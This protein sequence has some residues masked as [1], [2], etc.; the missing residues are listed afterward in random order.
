[1]DHWA[2][3]EKSDKFQMYDYGCGLFSCENQRRYGQKQPPQ[4]DLTKVKIPTALYFGDKD[5]LADIE[6]VNKLIQSLPNIVFTGREKS[7]SHLDYVWAVNANTLLY[8]SVLNLIKKY[9]GQ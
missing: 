3:A 7:Y 4:Y 5:A 8:Q 1:M 9:A 2:Q 6:D